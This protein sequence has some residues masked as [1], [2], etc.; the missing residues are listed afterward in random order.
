MILN[1]ATDVIY[2][3][4]SVNS[5]ICNNSVIW[6]TAVAPD[7]IVL[8][9]VREPTRVG[10]QTPISEDRSAYYNFYIKDKTNRILYTTNGWVR[11]QELEPSGSTYIVS[12]SGVAPYR[13]YLSASAVPYRMM[14]ARVFDG[15]H[16]EYLDTFSPLYLTGEGS[17]MSAVGI[18]S[19]TGRTS[20]VYDADIRAVYSYKTLSAAGNALTM[21]D[22]GTYGYTSTITRYSGSMIFSLFEEPTSV[23]IEKLNLFSSLDYVSS[24]PDV[25]TTGYLGGFI[26]L[27]KSYAAYPIDYPLRYTYSGVTAFNA[28]S[29]IDR[30]GDIRVNVTS[31]SSTTRPVGTNSASGTSIMSLYGEDVFSGT[32]PNFTINSSIG[33]G[34]TYSALADAAYG[35]RSGRSSTYG[36]FSIPV[37]STPSALF[38]G[39]YT[40]TGGLYNEMTSRAYTVSVEIP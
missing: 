26:T 17:F 37:S 15:F 39:N 16:G 14:C 2:N 1:D 3:G 11:R 33:P 40:T 24:T 8:L 12:A 34:P 4:V 18:I 27:W 25:S 23:N 30:T 13:V 7:S 6:P 36:V 10:T 31:N 9:D 19:S 22:S 5:V 28:F 35:S 29:N 38:L 21:C 32:Y 20:N